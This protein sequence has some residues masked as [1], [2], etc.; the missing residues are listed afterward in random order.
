MNEGSGAFVNF[1][2][3]SAP[4]RTKHPSL[5]GVFFDEDISVL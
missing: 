2:F 4:L 1:L 5:E 3:I